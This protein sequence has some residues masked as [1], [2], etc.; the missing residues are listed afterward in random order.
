[1]SIIPEAKCS[2]CDRKFSALRTRC[3]YCGA[4]RNVAGKRSAD[5]G[6]VWRMVVGLS[7]L[8]IL[9]IAIIVMIAGASRDKKEADALAS[10]SAA[11]AWAAE[12]ATPEVPPTMPVTP[13][14]SPTPVPVIIESLQLR[15]GEDELAVVEWDDGV[16][17]EY[18]Y[19]LTLSA[20]EVLALSCYIVPETVQAEITWASSDDKV[21]TVRSLEGNVGELTAV[22]EGTA[23]LNVTVENVTIKALIRVNGD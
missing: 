1:M 20:D 16:T 7:L 18:R 4:R 2:R 5:E 3:P 12:N 19:D 21:F 17:A 9:L 13:S 15:Y 6:S 11:A 22:G 8:A 23:Y 10:A 14:P